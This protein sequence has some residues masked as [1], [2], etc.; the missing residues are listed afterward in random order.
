MRLQ[1]SEIIDE[2]LLCLNSQLVSQSDIRITFA[3]LRLL[4][5]AN[6]LVPEKTGQRH[7]IVGSDVIKPG[8]TLERLQEGSGISIS[9]SAADSEDVGLPSCQF[10]ASIL[11]LGSGT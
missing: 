8:R 7:A 5:I 9:G 4:S 2:D 1:Y 11:D 6:D 10:S 3:A